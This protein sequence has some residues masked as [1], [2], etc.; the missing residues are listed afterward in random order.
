MLFRSRTRNAQMEAQYV[1]AVMNRL[2]YEGK[3]DGGEHPAVST[4]I[5]E[6]GSVSVVFSGRESDPNSAKILAV[7]LK[8]L[9]QQHVTLGGFEVDYR[10]SG[11]LMR[12]DPKLNLPKDSNGN[13]IGTAPGRGR[14]AEAKA[15]VAARGSDSG[16]TGMDTVWRGDQSSE[17]YSPYASGD[18]YKI[19]GLIYVYGQMDPCVTCQQ[20]TDAYYKFASKQTSER[21]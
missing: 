8:E 10:V 20:N 14:C 1:A 15:M 7:R 4:L 9:N 16:I 2:V 21:K 5:H 17:S 6:D 11:D 13:T 3:L 18:K 19:P 12:P